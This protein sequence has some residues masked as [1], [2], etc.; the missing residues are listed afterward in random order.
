MGKDDSSKKASINSPKKAK[1]GV[2]GTGRGRGIKWDSQ[3]SRG[4]SNS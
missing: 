2:G 4:Y 1:L 3:E